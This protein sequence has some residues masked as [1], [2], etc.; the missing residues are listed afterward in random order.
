MCVFPPRRHGLL[1]VVLVAF[2]ALAIAPRA[3]VAAPN[4][5]AGLVSEDAFAGTP[6]YRDAALRRIAAAGAGTVRQTLDWAA[7]EPTPGV[8]DWSRY[9]DY[10]GAAARYGV[11]VLPVVFNA[12]DWASSRPAAGAVRATYP[13]ADNDRFAAFAADAVRRY[14]P[15]GSFWAAHPELPRVPLTGWQVW[16]E[17][18]LPVYWGGRPDPAAYVA[19]LR[20]AS[21]AMKAADPATEVITAGM[22]QSR[23]GIPLTS[24]IDA[25]Y[26]AGGLGSFDA[27]AINPY[28]ANAAGVLGFLRQVRRVM[29]RRGD[30]SAKLWATEIGWSDGGPTGRFRLGPRGQAKAV[31]ATIRELWRARRALRLQGVIYFNWRDAQPYPGGRDFWGLHTGLLG[32]QG[33]AKPALHA[34]R[35]AVAAL[36]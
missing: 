9:D 19:L 27:V 3:A 1:A 8:R 4:P 10:V 13:P 18:N 24:Y 31:R 30:R 35:D 28:A 36:R 29:N 32:M 22:P 15:S 17:P 2:A 7:V 33:R 25:M 23:L 11:R 20:T 21:A 6:A 14:G 5:F 12:P 16:N 34:F 26:A